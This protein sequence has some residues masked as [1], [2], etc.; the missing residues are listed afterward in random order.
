MTKVDETDDVWNELKLIMIAYACLTFGE[1]VVLYF[2]YGQEPGQ[3]WPELL[4]DLVDGFSAKKP[5]I[6]LT[7]IYVALTTLPL[8]ISSFLVWII[9]KS[10]K[11]LAGILGYWAVVA[12]IIIPF[13]AYFLF[14]DKSAVEQIFAVIDCHSIF[15]N[16]RF[17]T[18]CPS[19]SGPYAWEIIVPLIWGIVSF[20]FVKYKFALTIISVS[21]GCWAGYRV[22][23]SLAWI[24]TNRN[25]PDVASTIRQM[26]QRAGHGAFTTE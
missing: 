22:R 18:R 1:A 15:E 23:K 4:K 19:F 20:Y 14:I 2:L 7:T 8:I 9:V 17:E 3:S 26:M 10:E 6:L 5:D 13:L 16:G 12:A 25:R 24:S 11:H 21:L